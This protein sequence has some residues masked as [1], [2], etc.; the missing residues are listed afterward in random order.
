VKRKGEVGG[1]YQ[2]YGKRFF[3]ST[4]SYDKMLILSGVRC[5]YTWDMNRVK[6]LYE[7]EYYEKT[8]VC[9]DFCSNDTKY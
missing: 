5:V 3:A 6:Q 7:E 9:T 4:I 8:F 1:F 2:K